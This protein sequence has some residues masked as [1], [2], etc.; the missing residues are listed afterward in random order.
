[1]MDSNPVFHRNE[2]SSQKLNNKETSLQAEAGVR[3]HLGCCLG[4][5]TFPVLNAP[6]LHLEIT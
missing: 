2:E 5:G 3:D 6:P 1:M 4:E